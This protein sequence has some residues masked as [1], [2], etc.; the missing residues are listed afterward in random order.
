MDALTV[1]MTC[2]VSEAG[3]KVADAKAKEEAA[4]KAEEDKKAEADDAIMIGTSASVAFVAAA[5]F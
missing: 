5:L 2:L 1:E 4:K 3:K